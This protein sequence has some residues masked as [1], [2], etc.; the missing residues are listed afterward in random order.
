MSRPFP[1][2]LLAVPL[3]AAL[4]FVI[5]VYVDRGQVLEALPRPLAVVAVIV[6]G[7]QLLAIGITRRPELGT[8]LALLAVLALFDPRVAL[9]AVLFW[10]ILRELGRLRRWDVSWHFVRTPIAVLFLVSMARLVISP[11]FAVGD[12]LPRLPVAHAAGAADSPD[13]FLFLLDGYPRSDTLASFGYDNSWF[14][15]ELQERGFT[16]APKSH[17]NY[18]FTYVV[19]PTLLHMRHAA[20][21]D[22]LRNVKDEWVA[23]RRAVR[24][25]IASA[26]IFPYLEAKGYEIVSAGAWATPVSLA[27]WPGTSTTGRSPNSNESFWPA[28]PSVG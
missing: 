1:K 2:S 3:L 21:I 8:A 15:A 4:T 11:A 16:I 22:E 24:D 7:I 27:K 26:P 19:V 28:R 12:L 13:M 18:T 6:L 20:E 25:A 9:L 5:S 10:L 17:S 14:E 23:Q